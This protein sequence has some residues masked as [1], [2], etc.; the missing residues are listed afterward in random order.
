MGK[1]F[2]ISVFLIEVSN[3][4]NPTFDI[5]IEIKTLISPVFFSG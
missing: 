2:K 1:Q 3:A 5:L 4:V